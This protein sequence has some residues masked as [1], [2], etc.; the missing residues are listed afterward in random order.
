MLLGLSGRFGALGLF[1]VNVV[2]LQSCMYALQPPPIMLHSI[3][4]ILLAMVALWGPGRWSIDHLRAWHARDS[5]G[6]KH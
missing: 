3:W 1:V 6:T 4:G 2:A 5:T